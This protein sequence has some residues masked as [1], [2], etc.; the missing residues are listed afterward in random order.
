MR[1]IWTTGTIEPNTKDSLTL[2]LGGLGWM[3]VQS[4]M[5]DLSHRVT[6]MLVSDKVSELGFRDDARI[7]VYVG[8]RNLTHLEPPFALVDPDDLVAV[9]NP[10]P[11][12][13]GAGEVVLFVRATAELDYAD[14]GK[15]SYE[16]N[17]HRRIGRPLLVGLVNFFPLRPNRDSRV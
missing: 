6:F 17:E 10:S 8:D 12:P 1:S 13:N 9:K 11:L 7:L 5:S 3:R 2:K 4:V 15:L 14:L 16:M